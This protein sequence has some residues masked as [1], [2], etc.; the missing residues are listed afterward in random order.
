MRFIGNVSLQQYMPVIQEGNHQHVH[1]ILLYE[2]HIEDSA[3]HY[4]KWLDVQGAQCFGAN[5]PLS[6]KQC[7]SPLVAW[8]IGGDGKRPPAIFVM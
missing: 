5:M 6:W 1:H 8:A 7:T 2:C 3:R 4:E